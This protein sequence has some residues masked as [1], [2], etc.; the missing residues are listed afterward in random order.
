[1][2]AGFTLVI[3]APRIPSDVHEVRRNE[4][5]SASV[6]TDA[7]RSN[8]PQWLKQTFQSLFIESV[9]MPPG[10]I[11]PLAMAASGLANS[12]VLPVRNANE[13]I[14]FGYAGD[15]TTRLL[16][17]RRRNVFENLGA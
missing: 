16:K 13:N 17:L 14:V 11:Q 5:R 15:F 12:S 8:G 7:L 1:M 4:I 10:W 6:G 2:Y 9:D 3:S